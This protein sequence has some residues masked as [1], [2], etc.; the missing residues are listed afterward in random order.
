MSGSI[1]TAGQLPL[2][3]SALE[4][5][6]NPFQ[7][8]EEAPKTYGRVFRV[9]I[10]GLSF[11]C[12]ADAGLVKRVL[13]E[14]SDRYQKDPRELNDLGKLLGDGLLTASGE[15]WERGR[16]HV[17]PAFY[18][19]KLTTYALDMREQTQHQLSDWK[20]G[21]RINAHTIATQLTLSIIAT[22]MFG[23]DGIEETDVITTAADAITERFK[24]SKLPME[25]P[26]WV[27]TPTNR[28][29]QRATDDLDDVIDEILR[30]R[31]ESENTTST[32]ERTDLCSTLL[33][34][35]EAG[36]L[37]DT[38]IR[39]HLVTMLFAGHETTAIGLTYALGLLAT[40][41]EQQERVI[42]EVRKPESLSPQTNLP[43]TDRVIRE[44][45][46]LYPPAYTLFRQTVTADTV[47]GYD[48]PAGTRVV[49]PQW[50]IHRSERYYDD[51]HEFQP[52]RWTEMSETH[53]EF[54]YFPFG[55]GERQCIGRR[56][57]LLE[58]RLTLATLLRS[59]R[60]EATSDTELSPTPALT[61]RPSEPVWLRIRRKQIGE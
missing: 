27:P 7:F 3:G 49:L 53:P 14:K 29:Y 1:P 25:L 39:D 33:S 19:G 6:Q 48:I 51:P 30:R 57:A 18:P 44:T 8:L 5:G 13:V 11:V 41:P 21:Q 52:D 10:P 36:S 17:Q 56:F 23:A 35:E 31:R 61:C 55:G 45:L 24:P 46:R 59:V 15:N 54:A 32:D 38:E 28:R 50:A 43:Y 4:I 47:A 40:N 16:K 37:S 58:L 26:L 12:F 34:A 20:D 2:L 60:F 22:T 9:S 42:N